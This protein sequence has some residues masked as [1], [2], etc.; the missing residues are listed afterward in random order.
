MEYATCRRSGSIGY[1]HDS[2]KFVPVR[3]LSFSLEQ[4]RILELLMGVRLYKDEHACLRE[5][6][7]NSLDACK[8]MIALSDAREEGQVEFWLERRNAWQRCLSLLFG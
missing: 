7:Q 6:Y 2:D 4:K 8:C 5:L 1:E 3:G